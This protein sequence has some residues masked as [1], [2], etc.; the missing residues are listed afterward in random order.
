MPK[1]TTEAA[2]PSNLL[3][4]TTYDNDIAI[5]NIL[6]QLGFREGLQH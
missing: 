1:T 6:S 4:T 3:F 2:K 5:V